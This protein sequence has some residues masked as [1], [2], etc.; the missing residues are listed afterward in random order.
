M[1]RAYMEYRPPESNWY[2]DVWSGKAFGWTRR[3]PFEESRARA[4]YRAYCSSMPNCPAKLVREQVVEK[5]CGNRG[6][7]F[8]GFADTRVDTTL[9]K[10]NR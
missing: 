4:L 5:T 2:V 6:P 10:L 9:T 8:Q 3:G 1:E 7:E